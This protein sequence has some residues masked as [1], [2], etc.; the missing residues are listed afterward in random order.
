MRSLVVRIFLWLWLTLMAVAAI[1]VVSAP[2]LTHSRPGVDRWETHARETLEDR[3]SQIASDLAEHG[4][5]SNPPRRRQR[6]P[7]HRGPSPIHV[8]IL[9]EHGNVVAG[10]DADP[11]LQEMAIAAVADGVVR[12]HRSGSQHYLI[13]PVTTPDGRRLAVAA[14]RMAP[15][16]L[17]DLLEPKGLVAPIAILLLA[18]GL[19]AMWLARH[20]TRPVEAL[21]S[22][23]RQLATGA[24]DTRVGPPTSSRHDEI[25][26]LARDF[27]AMT[28]RIQRLVE[29]HRR[30]L[31]DVSHELRSPL[32]RLGVALEL[33][34]SS[35]STDHLERIA[36]ESERLEAMIASLLEVSRLEA[37]PQPPSELNLAEL[38]QLV[39]DDAQLEAEAREIAIAFHHD[40]H[41][42]VV[43]GHRDLLASAVEN[44]IRNAARHTDVGTTIA[45][46]LTR[47]DNETVLTIR[48]H[49]P[50]V[51]EDTLS[52]LFE[53]FFRV[54]DARER[55]RG[56][57]G[58]GL[59]ITQRAVDQHGG[60]VT[61]RNHSE[62][63]LEVEIR[64]PL[65]EKPEAR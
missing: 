38:I 29:G 11:N 39:V 63:G 65:V 56:G 22:A 54:E 18:T 1:L 34:R 24:L 16:R 46:H 26:D 57:V 40:V 4:T 5:P 49:G 7:R 55:E 9:D 48:D 17:V 61:A 43:R 23:T 25:G 32:S 6:G 30:L 2:L 20:L 37:S 14:A 44:V 10:H 12:R 19:F 58:L 62:G 41:S 50:G 15:P 31:R 21:R 45:V 42:P 64:L 28:E 27:D 60:H 47:D 8:S 36:I 51:P 13:Q 59:A 3:I 52:R 33:V 35:G 53:P